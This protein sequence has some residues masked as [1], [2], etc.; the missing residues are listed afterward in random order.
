MKR[1][2]L[3]IVAVIFTLTSFCQSFIG[4][5]KKDLIKNI[6]DKFVKIEKP[7]KSDDGSYSITAKFQYSTIVYSFNKQDQCFFYISMER[8]SYENMDYT[9]KDYDNK[10]LRAFPD[11]KTNSNYS[12]YIWKEY[13][14]GIFI[15]RWILINTNKNLMFTLFLAQENYENNRNVYIQNLLGQ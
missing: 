4:Y 8:Y 6:E 3:T 1:I 12:M 13:N 14:R 2:L 9:V 11:L 7:E 15:Y 10:Y 5:T